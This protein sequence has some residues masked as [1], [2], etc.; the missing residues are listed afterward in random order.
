VIDLQSIQ[1]GEEG[2]FQ[3]RFAEVKAEWE[4]AGIIVL[5]TWARE[6]LPESVMGIPRE[7]IDGRLRGGGGGIEQAAIHV[8]TDLWPLVA[9]GFVGAISTDAW[10]YTKKRLA[11]ALK[12]LLGSKV[13]KVTIEVA[14]EGGGLQDDTYEFVT[15][16]L[17][18]ID[19]AVDA[20][21]GNVV[22]RGAIE[23]RRTIE[24]RWDAANGGWIPVRRVDTTTRP[25]TES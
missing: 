2:D 22:A 20:M 7:A 13:Q 10:D 23:Q 3:R 11:A 8:F 16:D 21:A 17:A 12:R 1:G 5:D 19:R 24:Y 14:D 25:T 9:A 6:P 15:D 4:A 18:H